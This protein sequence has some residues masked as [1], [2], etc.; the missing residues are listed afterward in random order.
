MLDQG[1][2][3]WVKLNEMRSGMGELRSSELADR[4][5][6]TMILAEI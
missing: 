4:R 1:R 5:S 3:L 6:K 2:R